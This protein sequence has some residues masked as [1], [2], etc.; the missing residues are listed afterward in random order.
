MEEVYHCSGCGMCSS[1]R[2]LQTPASSVLSSFSG[3]RAQALMFSLLLDAWGSPVL[4]RPRAWC[5]L[6]FLGVSSSSQM[7]YASLWVSHLVHRLLNLF[8][9]LLG[10]MATV[11]SIHLQ[12]VH[13]SSY[14]LQLASKSVDFCTLVFTQKLCRYFILTAFPWFFFF[15]VIIDKTPFPFQFGFFIFCILTFKIIDVI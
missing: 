1:S 4:V 10:F 15:F 9:E 7:P 12:T 14:L 11:E 13:C 6:L 5:T 2:F 8:Q 3:P